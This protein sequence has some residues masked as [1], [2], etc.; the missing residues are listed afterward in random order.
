MSC[1]K[2][3]YNADLIGRSRFNH[4]RLVSAEKA[5]DARARI[6]ATAEP[7]R[8]VLKDRGTC[9]SSRSDCNSSSHQPTSIHRP[10]LYPAPRKTPAGRKP[11]LS[12]RPMLAG[13]GKLT[14]AKALK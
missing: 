2:L 1:Y 9:G 7:S 6:S 10:H 11:T 5:L 8:I 4:G 3:D 14:P 12:C 13:L